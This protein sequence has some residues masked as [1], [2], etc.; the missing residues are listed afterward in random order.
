MKTKL[1]IFHVKSDGRSKY[2]NSIILLH[3]VKV[4]LHGTF[5]KV[6][7]YFGCIQRMR[8]PAIMGI[9]N[10]GEKG[11]INGYFYATTPMRERKS[12]WGETLVGEVD[13]NAI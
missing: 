3:K 1:D 5:Q 13:E 7:D 10:F 9:Y 4:N 6:M 12:I 2:Q 11:K 8:L